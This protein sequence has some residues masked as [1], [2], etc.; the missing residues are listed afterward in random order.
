MKKNE[1]MNDVEMEVNDSSE[2]NKTENVV[3]MEMED[4][5]TKED[6]INVDL[7]L[8]LL[9]ASKKAGE[10]IADKHVLLPIGLTG[11]G[12]VSNVLNCDM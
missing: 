9:I 8:D 3:G 6:V 1:V 12:K 10:K 5:G 7:L 4:T 2:T 11:A